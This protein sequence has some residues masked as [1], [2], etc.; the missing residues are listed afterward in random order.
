MSRP[1]LVALLTMAALAGPR[2]A[3]GCSCIAPILSWTAPPDGADDLPI[4]TKI[5]VAHPMRYLEREDHWLCAELRGPDGG[6]VKGSC[7][8]IETVD[9]LGVTVFHPADEL[10]PDTVYTAEIWSG[11]WTMETGNWRDVEVPE[12]PE[13]VDNEGISEALYWE[14]TDC[15]A[16]HGAMLHAHFDG[17]LLVLDVADA[18]T[19]DGERIEGGVATVSV[20]DHVFAGE[21][22]S[23]RGS[24]WPEA[25][26]LASTTVQL[27]VFDIAGNFSGFGDPIDVHVPPSGCRCTHSAGGTGGGVAG[28]ALAL[29]LLAVRR[30]PRVV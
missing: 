11:L 1:I 9:G 26:P 6:V 8:T 2:A 18:E 5:W 22:N 24:S 29:L 23:C 25:V 30:F 15:G 16:D 13:V 10:E 3:L 27:G 19:L 7:S 20:S 28:L 12:P 14:G 17:M 21:S 4:N